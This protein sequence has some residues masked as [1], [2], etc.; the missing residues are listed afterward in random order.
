MPDGRTVY[1]DITVETF[2]NYQPRLRY[3]SLVIDLWRFQMT[4]SD[5]GMPS[6]EHDP[7][8]RWSYSDMPE[9]FEVICELFSRV[10]IGG[11]DHAWRYFWDWLLTNTDDLPEG[12]QR[13][14]A[15]SS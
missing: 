13:M 14:L 15:S 7:P 1:G 8:F 9:E 10:R 11:P 5:D 12:L 3:R 2:Y 4:C 6:S